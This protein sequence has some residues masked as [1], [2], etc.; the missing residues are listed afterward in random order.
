MFNV[1]KFCY[2]CL[3]DITILLGLSNSFRLDM[4]DSSS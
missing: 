1:A 3:L 4:T 2:T